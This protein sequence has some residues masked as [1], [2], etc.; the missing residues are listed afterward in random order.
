MRGRFSPRPRNDP[1]FYG[2]EHPFIQTGDVD[3]E[4]GWISQWKQTLNEKGLAVSKKFP[5]GTVVISIAANIGT[6]GVLKFDAC[7]P[8]SLVGASGH[9]GV[10]DN[11]YLYYVLQNSRDELRHLAPA[12]AQANLS[13]GILG[14]Y[15]IPLPPLPEQR[16]IAARLDETF[17]RVATLRASLEARLAAVERLPAAL[18]REV[19]GG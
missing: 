16:A 1:Q 19:F 12:M 17:A 4:L 11:R 7:M 6:V 2:G 15:Q 10:G 5:K 9:K 18:L 3:S 13:L 14:P 8:D